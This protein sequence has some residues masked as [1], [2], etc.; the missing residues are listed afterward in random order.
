MANSSQEWQ[1]RL[2]PGE[3]VN[4]RLARIEALKESL[5]H[6]RGLMEEMAL[7]SDLTLEISALRQLNELHYQ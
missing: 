6:T 2:A 4:D 1:A 5:R 3:G 7:L